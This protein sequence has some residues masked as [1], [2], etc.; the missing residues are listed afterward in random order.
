MNLS[1]PYVAE[2]VISSLQ[3]GN[4]FGGVC[5]LT[6]KGKI[7]LL[8]TLMYLLIDFLINKVKGILWYIL[9]SEYTLNGSPLYKI[10]VVSVKDMCK[11]I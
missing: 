8:G 11:L 5:K 4:C 1:E 10:N 9:V 6:E 2:G 7:K 3:L